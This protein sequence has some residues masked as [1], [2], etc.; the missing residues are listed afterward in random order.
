MVLTLNSISSATQLTDPVTYHGVTPAGILLYT[1][2]THYYGDA[3]QP[4]LPSALQIRRL[5][6]RRHVDV[7]ILVIT[8]SWQMAAEL[9]QTSSVYNERA[10]VMCVITGAIV[11]AHRVAIVQ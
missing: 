5:L 4:T 7:Y 11:C 6:L 3:R 1:S 8:A 10:G 2:A 9:C